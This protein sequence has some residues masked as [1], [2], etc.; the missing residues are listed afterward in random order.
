MDVILLGYGKMGKNIYRSL[1][2]NDL[3]D[4]IYV[5]DPVFSDE[6]IVENQYKHFENIPA[7]ARIDAAFVAS[8]SVTHFDVL[9]QV[10]ARGIKNIFCEKPMLLT[11]RE[12]Q[13]I[14][15]KLPEDSRVVVDYILRSSKALN[16][17][18]Q[19][20]ADLLHNGYELRSCNIDYGKDKT[21]D[22]RRF[23]DI[24]VYEE[25]YHIWDLAFNGPLFGKI[26]NIRVLQNVYTPDPEIK[27]RC[28]QQ[29]FKYRV[30][31]ENGKSFLLN[32]NS[33]F[34]KD[35]LERNFTCLLKKGKDGVVLNL[36][37]DRN[38]ED[39]CT[40]VLPDNQIETYSFL[41]NPKLDT[42]IGDSITYFKTGKKASYLHDAADSSH[43]HN[44]MVK[45]KQVA[46][47]KQE[48]IQ[49]RIQEAIR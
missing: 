45:L 24:G 8:N 49:H 18:Q 35:H 4:K 34:Q 27:G 5:V 17:F 9:K 1:K 7:D 25:L 14:A 13:L 11:K 31:Q 36:S 32:L 19:A 28:I 44:L 26:K 30:Q 16:T 15:E 20:F 6:Q 38:G 39:V 48:S 22:P 42:I 40:K 2:K 10:V 29:R 43:F 12:Y 21:K 33:S 3:I 47:L 41:S 37:F 23:K 46:P